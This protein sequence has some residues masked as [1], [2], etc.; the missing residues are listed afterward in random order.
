MSGKNQ[1]D[2]GRIF[3]LLNRAIWQCPT[4]SVVKQTLESSN[5]SSI[6]H[7]CLEWLRDLRSAGDDMRECIAVLEEG[8]EKISQSEALIDMAN[9]TEGRI[10]DLIVLL[11]DIHDA[12]AFWTH[13]LKDGRERKRAE[14]A[15]KYASIDYDVKEHIKSMKSIV[16][17]L[18]L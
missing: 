18:M 11:M 7:K 15:S 10:D 2:L 4:G 12:V 1:S 6:G 14:E 9:H 3:H 5:S 13:S 17:G 8:K 16:E